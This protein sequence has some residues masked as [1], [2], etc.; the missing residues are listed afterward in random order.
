MQ[1]R[2]PRTDAASPA[3]PQAR[4]IGEKCERGARMRSSKV[5]EPSVAGQ[6]PV[7][8]RTV[9]SRAAEEWPPG[10]T[11]PVRKERAAAM[12]M[13]RA[14]QARRGPEKMGGGGGGLKPSISLAFGDEEPRKQAISKQRPVVRCWGCRRRGYVTGPGL[15]VFAGPARA[16]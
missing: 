1:L 15:G 6:A 5:S 3:G 7:V 2:W 9:D 4:Y 16:C 12:R 8:A 10:Y 11:R 13:P 14:E